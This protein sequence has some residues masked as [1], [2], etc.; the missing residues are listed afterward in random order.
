MPQAY[1]Y[2]LMCA[3]GALYAGWTIDLA[4]RVRAHMDGRAAKYTRSRR[5][6]MLYAFLPTADRTSARREEGRFKQLTRAEKLRE[7]A[8]YTRV[9]HVA[10]PDPAASIPKESGMATQRPPTDEEVETLTAEAQTAKARIHTSKGDIVFSFYPG[11]APRHTAAF[12]KLAR[13]G[14]YDGLTFHRVEPGFV[15][16]GGCPEGTGTGGPGYRL[17]A[18]FNEHPHVKGTVAMA[19][20]SDPNSGGSQF[21]VTLG[22]ARFLDRQYTVFGQIVEGQEVVDAIEKG[23]V[24]ETVSIEG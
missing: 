2:L 12:M 13:A 8:A 24:M 9:P 22:D 15:I 4:A 6:L 5:P 10:E 19:R 21:Y 23:D 7:A 11:E 1:V 16:Q 20:S 14:F 3:G 17:D 18:E